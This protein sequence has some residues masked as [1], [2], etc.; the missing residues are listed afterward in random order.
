VEAGHLV[1]YSFTSDGTVMASKRKRETVDTSALQ[2]QV[3]ALGKK[4][5]YLEQQIAL[6]RTTLAEVLQLLE[7][8]TKLLAQSSLY[9]YST[10]QKRMVQLAILAEL[11]ADGLVQAA[12]APERSVHPTP[13]AIDKY[14]QRGFVGEA[15]SHVYPEEFTGQE[16]D[17]SLL[18]HFI[19]QTLKAANRKAGR[20]GATGRAREELRA[21]KAEACM[22]QHAMGFVNP[23]FIATSSYII[24]LTVRCI[25]KSVRAVDLL[26]RYLPGGVVTSSYHRHMAELV[27]AMQDRNLKI[28]PSLTCVFGYDNNSDNYINAHR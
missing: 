3:A 8:K 4:N 11:A 16:K 20:G 10:H 18:M 19:S 2:A 21:D 1:H 13:L 15:T 17:C 5:D 22:L 9:K 28:P 14:T 7:E 12:L 26:G 27:V 23:T 6:A 25:T 24:G